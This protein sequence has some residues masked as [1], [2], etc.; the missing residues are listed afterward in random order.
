MTPQYKA[1]MK[2]LRSNTVKETTQAVRN[3]RKFKRRQTT[4]IKGRMITDDY[5]NRYS[6]KVSPNGGV[7]RRHTLSQGRKRAIR[8]GGDNVTDELKKHAERI[9]NY[10]DKLYNARRKSET[11]HAASVRRR[12]TLRNMAD[13]TTLRKYNTPYNREKILYHSGH[14]KGSKDVATIQAKAIHGAKR[15]PKDFTK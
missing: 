4:G 1:M 11:G 12:R 9:K 7:A 8:L 14:V 5:G 15:K 10:E 2:K 6:V 3:I 13:L